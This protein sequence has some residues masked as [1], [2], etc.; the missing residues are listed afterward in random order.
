[1]D[2]TQEYHAVVTDGVG[3]CPK[4]GHVVDDARFCPG[5]GQPVSAHATETFA[6]V[7]VAAVVPGR[8]AGGQRNLI[9]GGLVLGVA[10]L[11][12]AV[13]IFTL[14]SSGSSTDTAYRQT[15]G[16]SLTPLV[17]ANRQLSNRLMALQGSNDNAA[18]VAASQA[19]TALIA[20]R[21]A[22]GIIAVPSGSTQLS[23]QAQQALT[24][25]GGYLQGVSATLNDPTSSS[26]SQLLTLA[27]NTASALVP[28]EAVV[29]GAQASISGS[30]TLFSWAQR[31]AA[32]QRRAASL[33][34][35]RQQ[36]GGHPGG[37]T[38][39]PSLPVVPVPTG[40]DCGGGL[41]AGPNTSCGFAQNVQLAY[42]AAPG[43]VATVQAFSPATGLIYSMS[44]SPA[45]VGVTCSGGNNASV[46]W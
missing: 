43:A 29:P 36:H 12:A 13:V 1:M 28:L 46:S 20:A 35:H 41:H 40:S 31:Q 7:P 30:D 10:A 8:S 39:T 45:G 26:A 17:G 21:G 2:T 33:A 27:S 25:E 24:Q 5:C 14:G 37:I 23:Q 44:C 3:Y 15:L 16:T 4:C 22:V 11:V 9:A 32:A 42:N 6:R 34:Q 18:K 19:Q 38:S